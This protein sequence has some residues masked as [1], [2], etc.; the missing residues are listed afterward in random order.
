VQF[1]NVLISWKSRE[2]ADSNIVVIAI[3]FACLVSS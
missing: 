1:R 3:S 2:F